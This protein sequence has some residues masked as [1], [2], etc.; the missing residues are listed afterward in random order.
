MQPA[1]S[2]PQAEGGLQCDGLLPRGAVSV[3]DSCSAHR[4][5]LLCEFFNRKQTDCV[6]AVFPFFP[7]SATQ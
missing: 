1:G 2:G 4:G 3:S 5:V 7:D 6:F